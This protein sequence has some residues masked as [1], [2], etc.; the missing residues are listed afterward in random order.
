MPGLFWRLRNRLITFLH[1][2]LLLYHR[3]LTLFLD[4]HFLVCRFTFPDHFAFFDHTV[5]T[6]ANGNSSTDWSNTNTN[7]DFFGKSGRAQ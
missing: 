6:G 2:S 3:W 5:R 7:T 4:D 1:D